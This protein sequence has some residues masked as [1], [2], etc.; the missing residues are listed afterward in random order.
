MI[1]FQKHIPALHTSFAVLCDFHG[2]ARVEHK[3]SSAKAMISKMDARQCAVVD[4]GIYSTLLHDLWHYI[5]YVFI[6]FYRQADLP[7]PTLLHEL[8]QRL[9]CHVPH[10]MHQA[11]SV[12]ASLCCGGRVSFFLN[13]SFFNFSVLKPFEKE[14]DLSSP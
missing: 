7:V 11:R 9:S 4:C 6:R 13:Q 14:L 3:L 12:W 1:H 10:S 8:S 5:V 2:Y